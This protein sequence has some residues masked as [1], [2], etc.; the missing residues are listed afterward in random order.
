MCTPGPRSPQDGDS[1]ATG[2]GTQIALTG[3]VKLFISKRPLDRGGA[4]LKVDG[5]L[6]HAGVA[7]LLEAC[8]DGSAPLT[9]DLTDLRDADPDGVSALQRL[10]AADATLVDASPYIQLLLHHHGER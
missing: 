7:A 5:W 9:L 2:R 3:P 4:V 6:D 10:V 8:A 1:H